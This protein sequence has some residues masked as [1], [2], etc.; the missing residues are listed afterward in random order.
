MVVAFCGTY[1]SAHA[2]FQSIK[3]QT[4]TV[5]PRPSLRVSC[6]ETNTHEDGRTN[7]IYV[8][9]NFI[10]IKTVSAKGPSLFFQLGPVGRYGATCSAHRPHNVDLLA[11]C[12]SSKCLKKTK[13]RSWWFFLINPRN[14]AC[15]YIDCN[16]YHWG[17]LLCVQTYVH[18]TCTCTQPADR[19]VSS[20]VDSGML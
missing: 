14:G 20:F 11:N 16:V 9:S 6:P 3:S 15:M 1:S 12:M 4:A 10:L 5:H 13:S 2:P 8:H 17:L 18:C 19:T 7:P